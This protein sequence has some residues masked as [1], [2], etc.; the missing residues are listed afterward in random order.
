MRKKF[1]S[2]RFRSVGD[3]LWAVEEELCAPTTHLEEVYVAP[4]YNHLIRRGADIRYNAVERDNV[5]F[6][7][8]PAEYEA[9]RA[10]PSPLVPLAGWLKR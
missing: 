10:A 4:V 3:Y 9:L 5:I 2:S 8:V 1:V 7:G 6:C